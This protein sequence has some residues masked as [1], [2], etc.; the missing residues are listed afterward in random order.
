MGGS[1]GGALCSRGRRAGKSRMIAKTRRREDAKFGCWL[2]RSRQT[3]LRAFAPLR[4]RDLS[5]RVAARAAPRDRRRSGEQRADAVGAVDALDG[6]AEEARD[7]HLLDLRAALGGF[8][9]RD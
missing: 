4:L 2:P 6:L 8:G 1:M 9:Q 7:R 3:N 5:D